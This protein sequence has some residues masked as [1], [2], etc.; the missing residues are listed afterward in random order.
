M[1]IAYLFLV[2]DSIH[3]FVVFPESLLPLP[4][5]L[6]HPSMVPPPKLPGIMNSK[7]YQLLIMGIVVHGILF[8]IADQALQGHTM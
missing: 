7:C 8:V 1:M 6:L 4:D 2:E 5:Y 3:L